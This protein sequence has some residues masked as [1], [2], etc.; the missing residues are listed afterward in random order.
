M[1]YSFIV[2]NIPGLQMLKVRHKIMN[3]WH[4]TNYTLYYGIKIHD[5]IKTVESFNGQLL[6]F[7][8]ARLGAAEI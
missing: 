3:K 7:F 6:D 8:A 2:C 4:S 1:Q 5:T